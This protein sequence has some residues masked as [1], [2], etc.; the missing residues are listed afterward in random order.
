MPMGPGIGAVAGFAIVKWGGYTLAGRT[1]NY[2]NG[3]ARPTPVVF[4]VART[5]LGILAGVSYA[6]VALGLGL[7]RSSLT[8]YLDLLPVRIGEWSLVLWLFYRHSTRRR[9]RDAA[10]AS[11]WSYVLDIPAVAVAFMIP[12]GF[13]IC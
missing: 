7:E 1:F 9:L 12:G 3:T 5:A 13:W 8:W 11:V 10:V 6:Y 4:G 2:L